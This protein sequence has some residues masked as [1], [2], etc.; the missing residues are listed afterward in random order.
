MRL[1]FRKLTEFDPAG[2]PRN[3]MCPFPDCS[4][5]KPV[6]DE[7][8]KLGLRE[9]GVYHCFRCGKRGKIK[10]TSGSDYAVS[11]IETPRPSQ[12]WRK[13]WGNALPVTQCPDGCEYLL[14][15]LI[16]EPQ[17]QAAGVRY[18]SAWEHWET[19]DGQWGLTGTSP[20]VLFPSR[21]LG[22]AIVGC[23]GRLIIAEHPTPKV[24][25]GGGSILGVF[26]SSLQAYLQDPLILCEAPIDALSLEAAGYPALALFG[27]RLPPA[28]SSLTWYRDVLVATD[29]DS[30]GE[31]AWEEWRS[32]LL[33]RRA[34]QRLRP[35]TGKD[36]NECRQICRDEMRRTLKAA[37]PA[38]HTPEHRHPA[39]EE[40]E[41]V[42]RERF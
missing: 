30:A 15:R 29:N 3:W 27:T 42:L 20:R 34:P 12:F 24:I 26:A 6:D 4:D 35:P 18:Q 2:G 1:T 7:H 22:G 21:T 5:G 10:V 31:A 9:D 41:R 17:Q 40:L 37:V 16:L 19:K 28:I 39:S 25:T 13:M 14:N 8:R 33:T 23:Q 36:W 11:P 32:Q 38:F